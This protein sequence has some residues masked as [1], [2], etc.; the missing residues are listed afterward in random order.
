MENQPGN[1]KNSPFGNEAGATSAGAAMGG[2]DFLTDPS[3]V[4]GVGRDFTKESKNQGQK[5][6]SVAQRACPDSI[7]AGGAMPKMD[8]G[9][10]SANVSGT[11]STI[12]PARTPFKGLK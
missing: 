6:G 9:V 11:A 1:G 4:R 8:P 7:P 5:A 10:V 2:H 12:V 3:S